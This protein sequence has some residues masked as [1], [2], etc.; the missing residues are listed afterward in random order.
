[1]S[2]ILANGGIKENRRELDFYPTPPEVTHALMKFL[3]EKTI[4]QAESIIWEPACGA[5]HMATVIEKYS[6]DI[7]SSDIRDTGYGQAG[8]DFLATILPCDA[9]ITNPPFN[10]SEEFI[11]H[12][13]QQAPVVAMLLKSQYWHA[14]K[15]VSLFNEYPPAYVLPLTWRPDFLFD[16]RKNGAKGAPTME[17]HWTVWARGDIDTKY[18]LLSKAQL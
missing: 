17:V 3:F 8:I 15:R 6:P 10:L 13:F 14:A 5:G 18:R 11:R 16:Q 4:L 12:G 7:I 1:M 2:A 9:V